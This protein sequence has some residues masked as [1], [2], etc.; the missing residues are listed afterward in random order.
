MTHL[1]CTRADPF[2]VVQQARAKNAA[3][4]RTPSFAARH[5]RRNVINACVFIVT[6]RLDHALFAGPSGGKHHL[7]PGKSEQRGDGAAAEGGV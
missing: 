3:Q 7:R 6:H 5:P 4:V 1:Q 2:F